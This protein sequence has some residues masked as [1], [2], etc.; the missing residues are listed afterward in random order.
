LQLITLTRI[1]AIEFHVQ[2]AIAPQ[3]LRVGADVAGLNRNW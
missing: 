1:E 3:R 2:L